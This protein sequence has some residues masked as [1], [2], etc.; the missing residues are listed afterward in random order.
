[1]P[2]RGDES[3]R[4]GILPDNRINEETPFML[5]FF[6]VT[7]SDTGDVAGA[8]TDN[9]TMVDD[10]TAMDYG[11]KIND[12]ESHSGFYNEF[13]Y[14]KLDDMII[15]LD[16]RRDISS[17][18][19]FRNI[20]IIVGFIGAA[21]VF[22]IL[23][24]VSG[25]VL[26]PVEESYKK[27]KRFITD[28]S[29]EIKTPLAIISADA[30]VLELE[31]NENEWV[32]S[33]KKQVK[34]LSMLTEKLVMLSRMDEEGVKTDFTRLNW[35]RLVR[36]TAESYVP[37][38]KY[39]DRS[40]HI[41]VDDDIFVMGD[42]PNLIQLLNLLLE[43]AYKYSNEGGRIEVHLYE[44]GNKSV[45]EVYNTVDSIEPGS[46]NV[47]FERF[48][49]ADASRSSDTG[50]SGIGLSVVAAIAEIHHGKYEAK[51]TDGKS[52]IFKIYLPIN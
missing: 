18:S 37:M 16:C 43:N 34:R 32:L 19:Y 6:T 15:F 2:E 33:I 21:L 10:D 12:M 39:K 26:S 22:I 46:Q 23:S 1:M 29:H 52:I 3:G 9:I 49:R 14:N 41:H 27:Q 25:R 38:A 50:G 7:I 8:N 48:Y 47:L 40:Y 30:E 42:E 20:S 44:K 28:A 45:L 36:E 35:S 31:T 13:Y 24:L 11:K 51:S 4:P 17:F 5:R